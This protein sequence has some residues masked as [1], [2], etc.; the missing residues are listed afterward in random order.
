MVFGGDFNTWFGFNETATAEIARAFPDSDLHDRRPTFM[1]VLRLDHVF[2][3]FPDG[4]T[5]RVE[6]GRERYG[7]DHYPLIAR[8]TLR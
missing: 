8:I 5:G 2:F 4:W 1:N 3:R 6:R 7:S